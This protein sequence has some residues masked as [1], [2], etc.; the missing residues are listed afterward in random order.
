MARPERLLE[1]DLRH[2]VRELA[3]APRPRSSRAKHLVD[4]GNGLLGG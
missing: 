2:L 3:R 1:Q 4:L